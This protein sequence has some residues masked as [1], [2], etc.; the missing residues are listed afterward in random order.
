MPGVITTATVNSFKQQLLEGGHN[1]M[2]SNTQTGTTTNANNTITALTS[3]VPL[4]IGMQVTAAANV[5]TNTFVAYIINST[6]CQIS[7]TATGTGAISLN[8]TADTFKL[9]LIK[10]NPTGTYDRSITTYA[11]LTGN[12]D[13]VSGTGYTAGGFTLTNVSPTVPDSNTA[14]TTF[15]VNPSWTSA[16]IDAAGAMIYNNGISTLG[17]ARFGNGIANNTV[18]NHDF[19]GEQKVTNGTFTVTIPAANGTVGLLRIS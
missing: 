14:I 8:F 13:E 1:F 11:Q 6:A 12:T 10:F 15:S 2:A 5:A 17:L 18:S 9:A 16:T 19:G 7:N 3:T 4:V